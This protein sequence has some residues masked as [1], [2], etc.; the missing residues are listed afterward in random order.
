MDLTC[1]KDIYFE[2]RGRTS[3]VDYEMKRLGE[4]DGSSDMLPTIPLG[5]LRGHTL[6]RYSRLH[7]LRHPTTMPSICN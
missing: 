6:A 1:Q 7:Q 2:Y 5:R 4:L 3:Y